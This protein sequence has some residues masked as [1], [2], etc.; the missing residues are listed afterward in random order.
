MNRV[1]YQFFAAAVVNLP[2][3]IYGIAIAWVATFVHKFQD[4]STPLEVI[5][6]QDE[7]SWMAAGGSSGA[8]LSTIVC[9]FFLDTIGRRLT[10][11][12]VAFP[13]LLSWVLLLVSTDP[14]FVIVAR[15]LLGISGGG[16]FM[17]APVF[18]AEISDDEHRG[19]LGTL[20]SLS[21]NFGILLGFL[22]AMV[23]EYEHFPLVEM[24]LCLLYLVAIFFVKETPPYLKSKGYRA[25][26]RKSF[27]FYNNQ[28]TEEFEMAVISADE[29][30]QTCAPQTDLQRKKL[31]QYWKPVLLALI[32]ATFSCSPGTFVII[33]FTN[34]I[35]KDAGSQ[36]S[37]EWSSVVV[38]AIQLVG[39]YVST[40]IIERT[41]R[42][43]LLI[44]SSLGS[45]VCLFIC[46]GY[47]YA[48]NH[49]F[50]TSSFSLVP[51]IT[52]SMLF[53][54]FSIGVASVPFVLIT[55]ILPQHL[56]GPIFTVCM[57]E[58]WM[59]F[60]VGVRFFLPL[61][62]EVGIHGFMAMFGGISLATTIF[63]VVCVPETKGKSLG[64]IEDLF[65]TPR[66]A[67]G[68]EES[69]MRKLKDEERVI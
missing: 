57:I 17:A 44:F 26:A 36:L 21:C 37:P 61:I 58:M 43:P 54:V 29:V 27:L 59:I 30:E 12:F 6:T 52:I 46:G 34:I 25:A 50:D 40:L 9:G 47:Y 65:A 38:G 11:I 39:S 10:L 68:N 55:E 56:R 18:V 14:F 7:V 67:Y 3:A 16:A 28:L 22:L 24:S 35:F 42:K 51:L 20:L 45:S 63:I 32:A 64:S 1:A 31:L 8:I 19:M 13:Q 5:M 23:L 66:A 4:K 53:L 62:D 33:G 2:I 60:T 15:L 49:G 69:T 48:K 41:G